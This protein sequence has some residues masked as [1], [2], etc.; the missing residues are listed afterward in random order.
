MRRSRLNKSRKTET[1][2]VS[3]TA[4]A[5]ATA[6]PSDQ[7]PTVEDEHTE[8]GDE[9]RSKSVE[10]VRLLHRP[11]EAERSESKGDT[12]TNPLPVLALKRMTKALLESPPRTAY[13]VQ[14]GR[15]SDRLGFADNHPPVVL[16]EAALLSD[17]LSLPD[18]AVAAELSQVLEK[19]PP[20]EQ[21]VDDPNRD[22]YVVLGLAGT[23]RPAL[24]APQSGALAFLDCTEAERTAGSGVS[25]RSSGCG[26]M[27][28]APRGADRFYYFK[29][30]WF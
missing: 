23:L 15:L 29:G 19:F 8:P 20:P 4:T 21:F 17:R 6:E 28:K 27:S 26:G 13:A 9:S 1:S 18:A 7:E 16:L 24:L 2:D 10:A 25:S 3:D 22:L 12:V 30:S 14:V 11:L 5:T